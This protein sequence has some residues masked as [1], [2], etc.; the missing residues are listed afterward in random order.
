MTRRIEDEHPELFHYTGIDGLK[1]ILESQELWAAHARF[2][3][4]GAELIELRHYLPQVLRPSVTKT[5]EAMYRSQSEKRAVIER[6]GGLEACVNEVLR[7]C[8]DGL[9]QTTFGIDGSKPFAEAYILSFCTPATARQAE[10]GLLSQWRCYGKDG[11]YALV[12]DTTAV[13]G[14]MDIEGRRWPNLFLFGGDVLY[15]DAS[16]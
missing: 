10:H 1:G 5:L 15:S 11:G 4:D 13:S 6:F 2:L 3:N 7:G 14:A 8:V 9:Y 12:F 16:P